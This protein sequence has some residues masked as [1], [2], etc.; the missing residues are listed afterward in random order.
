M[1]TVFSQK[2]GFVKSRIKVWKTIQLGRNKNA[3]SIRKEMCDK[4]FFGCERRGQHTLNDW[5]ITCTTLENRLRKVKLAKMSPRMLG[6]KRRVRL[7][8]VI[9][10]A[11]DF[12]LRLCSAEVGPELRL[13]YPNQPPKECVGV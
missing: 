4:G 2:E 12:G 3:A 10:R 5:I 7:R 11:L 6:F 13:Q 9:A 1:S 8:S